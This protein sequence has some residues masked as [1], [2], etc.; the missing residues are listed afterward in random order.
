MTSDAASTPTTPVAKLFIGNLAFATRE[1]TLTST[2][3]ALQISLHSVNVVIK[4]GRSMGYGFV[5]IDEKDF[6]KAVEKLHKSEL[7]GR[8]INLERAT[9]ANPNSSNTNNTKQQTT[10][11]RKRPYYNNKRYK[12]VNLP[13]KKE[14][15][16]IVPNSAEPQPKQ[17]KIESKKRNFRTKPREKTENS[18]PKVRTK[19]KRPPKKVDNEP[20][21]LSTDELYVA[22]IPFSLTDAELQD[23]F[24]EYEC[25]SATVI[26]N[27]FGKN[28]GKTNR[29]F[30]FVKVASLEKQKAAIAQDKKLQ[31]GGRDISIKPAFIRPPPKEEETEEKKE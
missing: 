18:E 7:G 13:E 29:G 30:G 9:S 14:K 2:F 3:E 1:D 17:K 16:T 8:T 19:S 24:K 20:R 31:I 15:P 12:V 4:R 23:A 22:N 6:A 27:N 10:K 25:V 21:E 5:E 28:K 11:F 26:I